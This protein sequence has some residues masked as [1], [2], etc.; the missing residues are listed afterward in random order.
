[1]YRDN[2]LNL[3]DLLPLE[4]PE[5]CGKVVEI[6]PDAAYDDYIES[7]NDYVERSN[8]HNEVV[9]GRNL[10]SVTGVERGSR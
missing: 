8:D 4:E 9:S 10:Y 2:F 5:P 7:R 1:M 3:P 6:D